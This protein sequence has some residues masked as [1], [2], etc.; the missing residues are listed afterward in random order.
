MLPTM[1]PLRVNN[2]LLFPGHPFPVD[3][4]IASEPA[5]A[6]Q[7]PPICAFAD[8]Q[9]WKDRKMIRGKKIFLISVF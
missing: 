2:A 3:E 7:K 8:S 5:D 1:V 6:L 9:T 4:V